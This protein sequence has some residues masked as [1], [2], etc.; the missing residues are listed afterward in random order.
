MAGLMF[1][2]RKYPLIPG[3]AFEPSFASFAFHRVNIAKH[4]EH[5]I[6]S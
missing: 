1:S 4:A 2:A 3:E 6:I 5:S